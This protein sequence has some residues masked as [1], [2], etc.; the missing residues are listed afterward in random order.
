MDTILKVTNV[1]KSYRDFKLSDMN[2]EIKKGRIAGL[3]GENGAG[4]TTLLSLILDQRRPDTGNIHIFGKNIANHGREIKQK[5]GFYNDECCFH[6]CFTGKDMDKIL[7]SIYK[8]RDSGLYREYLSRLKVPADRKI[9]DLSKGT[10]NK[11]MLAA[12]MAYRPSLLVFDEITSGLDPI[13]RSSVLG[14][15]KKY[16]E[17]S[18]AAVFFSTHITTDLENFADEILFIH[19][20]KL[21]FQKEIKDLRENYVIY[22]CHRDKY[23]GLSKK[24][25][26]RVLF[27]GEN[28]LILTSKTEVL[29]EA[30]EVYKIP[31]MEDMMHMYVEGERC[32]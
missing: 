20:G 21:V 4:K 26:E 11:L 1:G 27:S 12:S 7:R 15:I 16:A 24:G 17:A 8:E 5:I 23:R 30:L 31:D 32:G 25:L 10:K 14:M 19:G 28:A 9:K 2:F 29:E 22:K 13:I 18:Q 6:P 3:I